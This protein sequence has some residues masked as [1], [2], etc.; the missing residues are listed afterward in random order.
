MLTPF[1]VA[2]PEAELR[3]LRKRVCQYRFPRSYAGDGWR[4]GCDADFLRSFCTSWVDAHDW[5]AATERLNRFPQFTA[6]VQGIR[7]H[8]VHVVGEAAGRRPLLISHGWPG[9][10]REFWK[11]VEP[12]AFPSRHAGQ[13][14]DAFDLVIPSL[15]GFGFSEQSDPPVDSKRTAALFHEL[16]TNVLG[17]ARFH[18]H[19]GDWGAQ[20]TAFLGLNHPKHVAGIH[21]T[22]LYPFPAAAPQTAEELAWAAAMRD[23]E[24]KLCGY[25]HLQNSKPQSLA[26]AAGDNPVG[27]AAWILERFHDWADLRERSFEEAFTM[28]ELIDTVM[29]YV[30]TGVFYSSLRFYSTDIERGLD[31]LP[32]GIKVEV[33]TAFTWFNDPLQPHPPRS[34][35]VKG[36]NV[37]RWTEMARG[38]HFPAL[39]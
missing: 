23:M 37:V 7:L 19:G 4:Y 29:I 21:M 2:W 26:W 9:S 28:E 12:L 1:Q 39:E 8:F 25:S 16:M 14:E 32:Q 18:A 10:H 22:M 38:G 30:M 27:Q 24:A 34:L 31:W 5:A 13:A 20:V 36:Y 35:V 17:Y 11:V 33:P 6:E 3:R 15:P